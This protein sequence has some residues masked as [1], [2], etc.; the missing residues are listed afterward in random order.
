MKEAEVRKANRALSAARLLLEKGFT[1]EA[2]G[3]SYYA[4]FHMARALLF[5]IDAPIPK[6]HTGL[7]SAFSERYVKTGTLPREIGK[8]LNAL[9][10]ARL[11]ADYSADTVDSEL[12]SICLQQAESFVQAGLTALDRSQ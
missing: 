12:A 11:I 1:D 2:V 10:D 9:Q 6:T 3:S 5:A 8:K 4:V 7:I